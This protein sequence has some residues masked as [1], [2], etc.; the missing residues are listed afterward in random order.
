MNKLR[1]FLPQLVLLIALSFCSLPLYSQWVS[2]NGPEG[3]NIRML[4][5]NEDFV[6]AASLTG[7]F[8]SSDGANWERVNLEPSTVKDC[9]AIGIKDSIVVAGNVYTELFL[10]EDNG[11]TWMKINNPP[12]NSLFEI[13][14]TDF[15]IYAYGYN[16]L[17]F[18][19][20]LGI[21]W[22]QSNFNP[23]ITYVSSV[24][25]FNNK[26]VFGGLD[27]L[28]F[29]N[30]FSD[31]WT[32]M[33]IGEPNHRISSL[34]LSD[35]EWLVLDADHKLLF[36]STDNGQN[37]SKN[38][39]ERW[40]ST[41]AEFGVHE[42]DHY[43]SLDSFI[44]RSTDGGQNWTESLSD[45]YRSPTSLVSFN[46]KLLLSTS[47][48]GVMQSSNNGDNFF[49]SSEGI[50]SAS[51]EFL[52][53]KEDELIVSALNGLFNTD[54]ETEE[55][56]SYYQDKPEELNLTD[57][58]SVNDLLYRVSNDTTLWVYDD[59]SQTWK[60][61]LN[62]PYGINR[63]YEYDNK[64]LV[65]SNGLMLWNSN[66][67]MWEDFQVVFMGSTIIPTS[68]DY[69][70]EFLFCG[71]NLHLYRRSKTDEDW[72]RILGPQTLPETSGHQIKEVHT[73]K[74]KVFVL[75]VAQF[76]NHYY[77]IIMSEDQGLT[78][79]YVDETFPNLEFTWWRRI[80]HMHEIGDYVIVNGYDN[81]LG[82]V[83]STIDNIEW[84]P[85]NDGL[86]SL[87]VYD[88]TFDDEYMYAGVFNHGVWKRKIS[89]LNLL[90]SE[91]EITLSSF[92]IYPNPASENITILENESLNKPSRIIFTD[93]SGRQVK[94]EFLT[95]SNINVSD[96][97]NGIYFV[98]IVSDGSLNTQKLLIQNQ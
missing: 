84:K 93:V 4:K 50:H 85:F 62:N 80:D 97:A 25:T 20:D 74:D 55:W 89:D 23:D 38:S 77:R 24:T 40:G 64:L 48:S 41:V 14:I 94:N 3:G 81:S 92:A 26:V 42:G 82:V 6:F 36:R 34:F 63:L 51:C 21:S 88:L 68:F 78:W 75:M 11:N 54:P 70:S 58:L 87:L 71:D 16:Q 28:Y 65:E 47:R 33:Y 69:N 95:D 43:I 98:S 7:L 31:D 76:D 60:T 37:W 27:S 17:W 53:F 2:M 13:L 86:P 66:I 8:R 49:P 35:S 18:S 44:V 22:I 9:R 45:S 19:P 79:K 91:K 29:S 59:L 96:L 52:T 32:A 12:V 61:I 5:K 90:S 15:A 67:E 72:T 56:N 30:E 46:S 73:I 83:I 57:F 39:D 1:F 10:S